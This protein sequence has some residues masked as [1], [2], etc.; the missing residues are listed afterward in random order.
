MD[1]DLDDSEADESLLLDI[2]IDENDSETV[3]KLLT[4]ESVVDELEL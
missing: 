4:L 2:E 3:D 1:C